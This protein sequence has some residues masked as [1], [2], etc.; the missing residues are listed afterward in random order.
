MAYSNASIL[1]A[2]VNKWIQPV[3]VQLAQ[4]RIDSFPVMQAINNK[5]RSTGWVP[6]SWSISSELSPFIE[7]VTKAMVSPILENYMKQVP[8]SAIPGIAHGIV[9]KALKN[10]ELS[11]LGGKI[12]F[13]REDLT[14]LKKLLDYNLPLRKTEEYEVRTSP[15]DEAETQTA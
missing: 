2:V 8:D 5:V 7:P 3:L 12:T 11:I 4:G 14:E 9:D 1:A 13:D 15:P 10:G 6:P